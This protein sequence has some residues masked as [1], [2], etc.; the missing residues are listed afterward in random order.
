[1]AEWVTFGVAALILLM[2]VSLVLY[3]WIATPPTPPVLSLIQSGAVRQENGQFYVP[4]TITNTGGDTAESV[5]IIAELR[6]DG[7]R[8]ESGEQ[9]IDFLAGAESEEGAFI[10]SH[11]P[12]DGELVMRV[13]S[14]KTP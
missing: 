5:Q 10:F 14:Y 3:D 6:I 7:S 9:Q 13:A 2:I 11:N 12:E 1:L 4:F 8:E